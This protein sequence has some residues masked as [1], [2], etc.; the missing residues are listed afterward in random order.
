MGVSGGKK[1]GPRI[2]GGICRAATCVVG[3]GCLLWSPT[4]T[5]T[6]RMSL[7]IRVCNV[8][9]PTVA[10]LLVKAARR[11]S[12]PLMP[13]TFVDLRSPELRG[14]AEAVTQSWGI[15]TKS[16]P[17]GTLKTHAGGC[18]MAQ[19]RSF[20]CCKPPSRCLTVPGEGNATAAARWNNAVTLCFPLT[21]ICVSPSP[22]RKSLTFPVGTNVKM[23]PGR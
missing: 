12:S 13:W 11:V 6:I 4:W 9:L 2:R 7:I 19:P 17:S 10:S 20:F 8:Y 23:K 18:G 22:G 5:S 1:R 3:S 21:I 14:A 16:T 15:T